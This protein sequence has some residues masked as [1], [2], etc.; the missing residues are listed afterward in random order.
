MGYY[1]CNTTAIK[2]TERRGER[3]IVVTVTHDDA[4]DDSPYKH[5][6]HVVAGWDENAV[7][8][9]TEWAIRKMAQLGM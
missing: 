1:G 2:R 9:A 4:A 5:E 8:V 3:V 7:R 6:E